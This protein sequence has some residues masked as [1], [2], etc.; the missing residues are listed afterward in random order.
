MG[1]EE[2]ALS[3]PEEIE[4]VLGRQVDGILLVDEGLSAE[5]TIVD[6]V[7]EPPQV[8]RA[9]KGPLDQLGI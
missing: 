1:A 3:D 5:T 4:R 9:G 6:L 2:T 8:I 7:S